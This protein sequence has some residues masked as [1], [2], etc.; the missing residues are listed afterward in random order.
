MP[1]APSRTAPDPTLK[2]LSPARRE[3]VRLLQDVNFGRLEHL[4]LRDGEPVL[5]GDPRLR[6]VREL[7]FAADNGPRPEAARPRD[8]ALKPQFIDLF[9]QF[10]RLVDARIDVLSVRD[11]LP[12]TMHVEAGG[13]AA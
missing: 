8:F 11:G 1:H 10:D 13:T 7:K 9:R 4:L 5:R 2:S 12:Y 3:L 6:V